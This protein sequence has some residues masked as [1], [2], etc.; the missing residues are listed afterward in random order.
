MK[1][2]IAIN[3]RS[4]ECCLWSIKRYNMQKYGVDAADRDNAPLEWYIATGRA[5]TEFIRK[6]MYAK[7][8]MI[9]RKLHM[10]GSY[11]DALQRIKAYIGYENSD[12]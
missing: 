2:E 7:P 12:I 9:A 8:F 3:S 6:L 1:T 4:I 11:T 10:G 5:S